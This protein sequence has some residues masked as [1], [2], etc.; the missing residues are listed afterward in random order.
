MKKLICILL[1]LTCFCN[2]HAQ[3]NRL[4]VGVVLGG[5]GAKG[6]AEV[7]VLHAI[8]QA[9]IPI[10]YIAGT[11]I[12]A[13]VGGLYASGYTSQ[14]LDSLFRSQEWLTLLTDRRTDFKSTIFAE[15]NGIYYLFGFP[16]LRDILPKGDY[17]GSVKGDSIIQLLER[18][19]AAK[20]IKDI[21]QT[22]IPFRCVA[23]EFQGV[24]PVREV[25]LSKGN[26]AQAMRA[27]MAIPIY[28]KAVKINNKVLL[29][30]GFMNNL[31]VDVVKAMGADVVIAVDLTQ[32]RESWPELLLGGDWG[33]GGILDWLISRP[34]ISKY[35]QN[36]AAVDVYINPQLDDCYVYSFG[37]KKIA[38]MLQ[39]GYAAGKAALPKLKALKQ[40][41]E[42][43]Q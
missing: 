4:R 11:S 1:L 30:G 37:E 19:T 24:N 34:D 26:I 13:I 39:Q 43:N 10:D 32:N 27:S 36:C 6:A 35:R 28:F 8:E 14:Q 33:L 9:G 7:G 20:N 38:Q 29:D 16:L 21:R 41:I 23:T 40:R 31:P 5:G 25:V 18:M 3:Q 15:E 2:T 42:R 22:P 12:G 17:L